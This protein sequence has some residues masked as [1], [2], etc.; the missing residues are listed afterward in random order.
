MKPTDAAHQIVSTITPLPAVTVPLTRALDCV[1]AA[2]ITSP[3]NLPP[4]TNSAMDGYATRATDSTEGARLKVIESVPAG[5]FPTRAL[6]PG[7]ATRIF[8][9]APLPEGAD[10]VIRQEDTTASGH[11][12]V[13][14]NPRDAGRNLRH[15]GEDIA[16]GSTVLT[17][18]TPLGPAQ[19]G[20]LASIAQADV[21]VH[22]RPVV[23]ILGSGDEIVDLDRR[24]E[25]LAG[26]K[27]ATSNSY[28]LLGNLARAGVEARNLGL[29][30]DD[31]ADLEARLRQA[32]DADLIV[33]TA[34]ISVGEHDHLR[35][36]ITRLGGTIDFWRLRMRP[37][38]PV[39]FG[40]VMG[41]PWIGLPG[42]PVS[43]MVT[44]ELFVLP[45]IRRLQGHAL[46]FRR[47]VTVTID[48]PFAC[49]PPLTHFQ[50]GCVRA[51]GDRLL[52]RLTGPQ[53]SGIL[54][55]MAKADALL[56]VPAE[57]NAVEAGDT[58]RAILLSD[59]VFR[60]TPDW[61]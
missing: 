8:T 54:T 47:T 30:V 61:E 29:A 17:R 24:D 15:S 4:W 10:G 59:P 50:R 21:S 28:T 41:V 31:P 51:D 33:T 19:L 3:I 35:E 60:A 49:T 53:G 23:A 56:I 27:I 55:S 11:T 7:E 5:A 45:A 46:P 32:A 37:G 20:V 43:A 40:Q 14:T 26:T 36:V 1:L 44:Y 6:G 39:G 2:D 42:N 25:I 34:G 58:L 38:A 12:V 18:G 16:Q 57:V 13:I 22:R 52:A 48:E 9:G